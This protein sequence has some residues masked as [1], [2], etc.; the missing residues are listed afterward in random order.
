MDRDRLPKP[1]RQTPVQVA[2]KVVGVANTPTT[3]DRVRSTAGFTAGSIDKGNPED[4]S[5]SA[6]SA[7]PEAVLHATTMSFAPRP[8]SDSVIAMTKR[9]ISSIDRGRGRCAGPRGTPS[10]RRAIAPQP[11]ATLTAARAG[12]N[13]RNGLLRW[14]NWR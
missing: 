8:R 6:V 14:L 3:P 10:T 2:L 9:R 11:R 12:V 7:A 1:V 4:I 13:D 5:R